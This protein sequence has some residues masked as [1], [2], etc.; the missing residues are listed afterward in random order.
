MSDRRFIEIVKFIKN[1]YGNAEFIPLHTP[2]FIGN[3]KKYV[4]DT[5]DSTMV[6]SVGG[7][8]NAFEDHVKQFTG[9]KYAIAMSNGT[10]ALQIALQ[11]V[12]VKHGDEVLT[13]ALTF[14]ATANAIVHAGGT[15]VFI[16]SDVETMGMSPDSLDEFLNSNTVMRE[17]GCYNAV[18]KKKISA[19]LPMHTF[20]HPIKIERIKTLCDQFKIALIEDAAESLGSWN[21]GKHTGLSGT[22]GTLSFNGNKIVTTGGGGMIITDDE[23]VGKRA[24]HITTT[25]KIS[26]PY[27]FFHDEVGY[28]FR[29]P[30]INAA[31]GCAQMESLPGFLDSKRELASL[32]HDFF[33]SQ[34]VPFFTERKGTKVNYWLN[35]IILEGRK[36][37][38]DFLEF[39]NSSGVMT[40]PIWTLMNKLPMYC[41]CQSTTLEKAHWL[42]DR[43][44]NLPSSPRV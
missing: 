21:N 6:S 26:H 34:G 27:E 20:G 14:V 8:V 25:A 42:E 36:E 23:F 22:L 38:N 37:R 32:Y 13:Q 5:I 1:L 16:D 19:C 12:G 31:L 2:R 3:E 44:V 9:A 11:L 43:V 15:P 18:T 7:Y 41:R 35:C 24:K 33:E 10:V 30:N 4:I 29:L 17:D 39:T 40:R 28:N